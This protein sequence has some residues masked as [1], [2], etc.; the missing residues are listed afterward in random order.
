[1][2]RALFVV[3]PLVLALGCGAARSGAEDG[4]HNPDPLDDISGAELYR[5]GRLLGASGDF[6]RAEQYFAAAIQRGFSEDQAMPALMQVCIEASRLAAAL[7]YAEPY[8]ARHP[9][10]WSLRMLVASI[11]MG[12][13]HLERARD[14]LERVLEDAPEEPPQAHY[15]LGVL[16]RDELLDAEQAAEHF[17]RYL[18]LAP[19]GEH[20]EEAAAGISPQTSGGASLPR[21]VDMPAESAGAEDGQTTPGAGTEEEED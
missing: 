1:M 7:S 3:A 18:A 13:D 21:R 16:F 2:T 19:E 17:E 6:I 14:E 8:L 12:L 5:R 15:F 11:H 10:K 20:R 4:P 9:D